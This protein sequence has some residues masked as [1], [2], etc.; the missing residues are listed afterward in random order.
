[1]ILGSHNSLT[2]GEPHCWWMKLINFTSKCQEL[3]IEEQWNIGVRYYDFRISPNYP[4]LTQHGLVIYN[5][6]L[7]QKLE[8][9]NNMAKNTKEKVYVSVNL[10]GT[11]DT[12]FSNYLF[13]DIVDDIIKQYQN[14]TI[15]GGYC[16]GPWHKK[17]KLK[18]P[19]IQELHWEFMNWNRKYY[20][21][22]KKMKQLFLNILHFSPR[23]WAKKDNTKYRAML[24]GKEEYKD[25]IL[26]LDFVNL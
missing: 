17:L 8:F 23:Y 16:K 14:L 20:S 19:N 26:M 18:D 24:E 5:V 9:L 7:H 1:M 13:K 10:E 22:T 4:Y 12:A 25:T 3:T 6:K 21:F 2:Y 15:C 11:K